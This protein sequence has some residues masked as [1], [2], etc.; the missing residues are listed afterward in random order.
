MPPPRGHYDAKDTSVRIWDLRTGVQTAELNGHTGAVLDVA[1]SQD[2]NALASASNDNTARLWGAANGSCR[3]ILAGHSGPVHQVSF[4][5][6]GSKALTTS[7]DESARVWAADTGEALFTLWGWGEQRD[8][9]FKAAAAS[10]QSIEMLQG[11]D[12]PVTC[13]RFSPDGR[14]AVTNCARLAFVWDMA[15]GARIAGLQGA[16]AGA[17]SAFAP[18]GEMIISAAGAPGDKPLD[19]FTGGSSAPMAKLW[20]SSDGS[21]CARLEGHTRNITAVGF[22]RDGTRAVTSAGPDTRLWDVA[23]G[24]ELA[25]Y[26]G[27]CIGER[28]LSPHALATVSENGDVD[29]WDARWVLDAC[30]DD[31]VRR[32]LSE[33][34]IG[35]LRLTPDEVLQLEPI[36]GAVDPDCLSAIASAQARAPRGIS[37]TPVASEARVGAAND[38]TL[39]RPVS[40]AEH[41]TPARVVRQRGRTPW[42]MILVG[43]SALAGLAY[44]VMT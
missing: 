15:A 8:P 5:P 21:E 32:V 12:A 13:A 3:T 41:A 27:T 11:L 6:D 35:M 1:F 28:G 36:L 30:D 18:D 17:V 23:S 4:S 43:L 25:C 10:V 9:E 14:R 33:R 44:W 16:D 19:V 7:S 42:I 34:M 29:V 24:L 38:E 20:R 2:G 39:A 22:S 40:D 37:S 31:L 26:A